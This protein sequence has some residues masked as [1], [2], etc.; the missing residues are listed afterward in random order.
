MG[1]YVKYEK[2]LSRLNYQLSRCYRCI[3][4]IDCELQPLCMER[5]FVVPAFR[6]K[7]ALFH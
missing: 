7:E 5:Y 3:A 4:G 2:K 1:Q 6:V